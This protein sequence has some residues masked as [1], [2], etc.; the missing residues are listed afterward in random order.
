[1]L[2]NRSRK[3][4]FH[5]HSTMNQLCLSCNRFRFLLPIT[6]C[7]NQDLLVIFQKSYLSLNTQMK[8]PTF[9][10]THKW[11][12]LSR[13]KLE[14]IW[15]NKS[16]DFENDFSAKHVESK[17]SLVAKP[18]SRENI[19]HCNGFSI[20][21]G[22][23]IDVEVWRLQDLPKLSSLNSGFLK[24]SLISLHFIES[25]D[26]SNIEQPLLKLLSPK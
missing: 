20:P 6:P 7:F 8:T 12:N 11:Y 26:R 2:T 4:N 14:L 23:P 21:P 24:F 18:H 13:S 9:A 19:S 10:E 5:R 25:S 3:H 1:M 16:S 15:I 17:I 22:F